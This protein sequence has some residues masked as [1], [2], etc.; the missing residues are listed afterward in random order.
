MPKSRAP[1][2]FA[3]VETINAER[4]GVL[5]LYDAIGGW[6]GINAK[7]VAEKLEALKDEG[8]EHLDIRLNS[9]GGDVWTG[10]AIHSAIA[11]W[12]RG[13]KRVHID[14]LAASI[15]S[16]IAM[17]G[18]KIEIS[19]S[20]MMMVHRP[21]SIAMG[22]SAELRKVADRLDAIAGVMCDLYAKRTGLDKADVEKLVAEETWM[23]AAEAVEKGFA[24]KIANEDSEEEEE[25]PDED[26]D[27]DHALERV[28]ALFKRPPP[29]V[30]QLL[31]RRAASAAGPPRLTKE[32]SMPEPTAVNVTLDT[33]AFEAQL[34]A[35]NTRADTAQK[36]TAELLA[37]TGKATAAEALAVVA[38]LK[39]KAA[40]ADALAAEVT[41]R[42]AQL[43]TYAAE[44][45]TAE[46][47]ALFDEASKD[48]RL[49]PAKRK[50]LEAPEAPP[51]ARDPTALRAFLDC[52]PKIVATIDAPTKPAEKPADPSAELTAE[53]RAA[54]EARHLDLKLVALMKADPTGKLL[55]EE[56]K[57]RKA[58]AK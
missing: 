41:R 5:R 46:L 4:R 3:R 16:V 19:P 9:P 32:K 36:V 24:D 11:A 15:A 57:R 6:D 17:A 27:E 21:A 23:S 49:A 22:H 29:S 42:G 52:L 10:S 34:A 37:L 30:A 2:I 56:L 44:K 47:K 33:K 50:E 20:A 51:F 39:E 53:E 26:D 43:A 38:G 55:D 31:K 58:A 1:R 14:G 35:A 18:D 13:E 7:D 40:Q 48:G 28:M 12:D 25:E 8:A 45:R 54:A